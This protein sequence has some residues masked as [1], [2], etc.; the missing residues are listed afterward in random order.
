MS[1]M[2][3]QEIQMF[4]YGAVARIFTLEITTREKLALKRE[5]TEKVRERRSRA[6]NSTNKPQ[7]RTCKQGLQQR[8]HRPRISHPHGWKKEH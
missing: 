7:E 1:T 4:C 5:L 3:E 2:G 6:S 8:F